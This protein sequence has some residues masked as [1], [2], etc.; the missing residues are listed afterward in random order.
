MK[1]ERV[2]RLVL[3][4]VLALI[5]PATGAFAGGAQE[6]AAVKE[7]KV[8]ACSWP[9]MDLVMALTPDFEKKT[10]IKVT[11]EAVPYPE[12]HT[13][14]RVALTA[15]EG[16][17]DLITLNPDWAPAFL[18]EG[19]LQSYDAYL[20]NAKLAPAGYDVKDFFPSSMERFI[21]QDEVY[22]LP[23]ESGVF[24]NYY[25]K[26]LFEQRGLKAPLTWDD[27]LVAAQ[28]TTIDS[29]NDGNIDIY[30]AALPGS[31]GSETA[32]EFVTLLWSFGGEVLDKAG[33]VAFN[34][35]PGKK[36]LQY[37]ADLVHK[38]KVVPPGIL[39]NNYD[40][41]APL[42]LEGKLAMVTSWVHV[43]GM[44]ADPSQSKVVDKWW[45]SRRP[46]TGWTGT[47]CLAT[48]ADSKKKEAAFQLAG[49]LTSK[50][51]IRKLA[52]QGVASTR[53]SVMGDA[54]ILSKNPTLP[55]IV[56]AVKNAR[57]V[58][59]SLV[60]EE[61]FDIITVNV[62][63]VLAGTKSVDTALKQM[64]TEIDKLPAK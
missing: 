3:I 5:L 44:A 43:A 18:A 56:D 41:F 59:F 9:T 64:Q 23:F 11:Y 17:Y 51:S 14:M 15:K 7:L 26:D 54:A 8:L 58:F 57:P 35:P 20:K 39:E 27:Y 24:L 45:F 42:F 61:M 55:P 19:F 40:T 10:G 38:Y 4:V 32:I 13:K 37:E 31:R 12:L 46:G 52:E 49:F 6:A 47:W 30:G 1:K 48:P 50:E 16:L 63:E 53:A 60:F 21:Y 34:S 2:W 33:K 36:A 25:R 29:N 22:G 28:K 62:S